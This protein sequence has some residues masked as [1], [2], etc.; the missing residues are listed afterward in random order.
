MCCLGYLLPTEV[1][2]KKCHAWRVDHLKASWKTALTW[3]KEKRQGSAKER[4]ST[5]ISFSCI[6]TH[7]P[8]PYSYFL[9][10]AQEGI[11][12]GQ[13]CPLLFAA[14]FTVL[15]SL[16]CSFYF[17]LLSPLFLYTLLLVCSKP[18]VRPGLC[19]LLP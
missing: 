19:Y 7:L 16:T 1:F 3:N 5:V 15:P 8:L 2:F 9:P 6:A 14:P 13:H 11:T 10:R 18:R 17:S 12:A 4:K